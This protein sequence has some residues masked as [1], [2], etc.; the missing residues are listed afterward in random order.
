MNLPTLSG[1]PRHGILTATLLTLTLA[2]TSCDSLIY[3]DQG[4]C[5]VHYRVP[6]RFTK[7]ILN[8]DA[9][10]SQVTDVNLYLFDSDGRLAFHKK[11]SRKLSQEND[12]YMDV[13]VLPG[14]YSMIAWCEGKSVTDG[15][16]SFTID[17]EGNPAAIQDLGARL[18]LQTEGEN[19][20]SDK[21]INRLY[22]GLSQ[23]VE[24]ADSF[25]IVNISPIYLTK[26][27]NHIT[28]QLLNIDGS[29][30]DPSR[31]HFSLTA[32]NSELT[33]QNELTGDISFTYHPWSTRGISMV[34][35]DDDT[36][37]AKNDGTR[38]DAVTNGVQA[39]LTT[40]RL[41][42]GREQYLTVTDTESGDRILRVP[43][44][45]YLL[46]VRSMYEQASSDQDYL[47][48]YDDF[49][50]V[51]FVGDDLTWIKQRVLINGWRIVPPQNMEL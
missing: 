8:A 33:W 41:M 23:D 49:S 5:A 31:L 6:F 50:L 3:D 20:F 14:T 28:V 11:E 2:T 35:D 27:T 10:A 16:I 51:F 1:L 32:D 13:E 36:P 39:E 38:A 21:D 40:G 18:P 47:D 44:V 22:Y 4:D 7:N 46:L 45:E 29:E 15:A 34:T 19:R 24:F 26:D 17:N 25:G 12:Y 48:R 9:F 37:Q 42:A 43:L 30:I